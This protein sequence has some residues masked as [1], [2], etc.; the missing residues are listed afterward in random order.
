MSDTCLHQAEESFFTLK[1]PNNL[2]NNVFPQFI[3]LFITFL[4]CRM[5]WE[6]QQLVSK[7]LNK[8]H[9][10]NKVEGN[11]FGEQLNFIIIFYSK[12][13]KLIV[14]RWPTNVGI[15]WAILSSWIA[16]TASYASSQGDYKVYWNKSQSKKWKSI[17]IY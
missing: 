6:D 8:K 7:Y 10:Y 3:E 9:I 2:Q 15:C 5:V 17:Q 4:I 14:W 13:F 1:S 12:E 11:L 16:F